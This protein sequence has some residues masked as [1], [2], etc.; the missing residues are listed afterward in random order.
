MTASEKLAWEK[1][2]SEGR[3][4]FLLKSIAQARWILVAGLLVEVCWFLVT[5]NVS[6]PMWEIAVGWILVALGT[7]A[8]GGLVDWNTNER[9]YRESPQG[10]AAS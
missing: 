3:E 10:S 4:R 1:V 2:R 6:K 8:W 5:R 9:K 7:G